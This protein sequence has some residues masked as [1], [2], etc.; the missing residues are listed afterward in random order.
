MGLIGYAKRGDGIGK[1][2]RMLKTSCFK[3]VGTF[4][5]GENKY[6]KKLGRGKI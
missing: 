4:I 5:V 3:K 6:F 1:L 2:N